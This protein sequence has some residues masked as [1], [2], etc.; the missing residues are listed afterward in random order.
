MSTV[1]RVN[2]WSALSAVEADFDSLVRRAFGSESAW[3]PPADIERD[4]MDAVITLEIPGVAPDDVSVEVKN[5][6]LTISGMRESRVR[7]SADGDAQSTIRREIRQGEFSRSFR[8]PSH[9]N[10]EAVSAAYRDGL[11]EIRVA[12]VRQPEPEAA[13]IPVT[14]ATASVA[15]EGSVTQEGPD[16]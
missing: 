12:G 9:L 6:H 1:V 3:V 15:H 5:R 7:Q 13:R 14:A 4:G 16:A 8:L 2:P 11:L 10:A